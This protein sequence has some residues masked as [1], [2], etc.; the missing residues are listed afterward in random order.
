MLFQID[1]GKQPADEV[2]EGALEQSVLEGPNA[3][4]AQDLVRGA[5]TNQARIDRQ[6]A[7]LTAE[8]SL[9]RQAA[10]DRN[11]L[12]LTAFEILYMPETPVASVINEAVELA[13][14]YSTADSGRFVN[15]VL[16]ALSRTVE[17]QE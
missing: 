10:V 12:R 16:G 2:I 5:L 6:L 15:G 3:Q 1:V 4:F 11:I 9:E 17:A 8:W 13:K 14:K 7:E